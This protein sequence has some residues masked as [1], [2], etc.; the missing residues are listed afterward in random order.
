MTTSWPR[1]VAIPQ[2]ADAE[3][4]QLEL[5]RMKRRATGLLV[6]MSAVFLV[7]LVLEPGHPWLGYVRATAEAAMVGG[8]ADWFAI[9]ALFKHPL[10]IPIPHT[11]I[12]PT[13][14]DRIGRTL[15]N[16]VQHNFL[17]PEILGPKLLATQP[18]RR[19]A[20]WLRRPEN[21]RSLARHAAS[22][23]RSATDVVKDEDVHALLERSVIE[24]LRQRP[25]A[26][27]LAKGLLLLTAND[28]HQ[29]LLDRMIT[30]LAGLIIEN[31][32]F[33][34]GRIHAESPWWV[35][36][37][38]DEQVHAKVVAGIQRTLLEVSADPSHPMRQQFDDLL[39]DWIVRLQE[40]PEAI[41]RADA[42]KQQLFD[43]PTSRGLSASLWEE[44]KRMLDRQVEPAGSEAPGAMER[45]LIALAD[46]AL[47]D[48]VLLA[49]L[50][51]WIVEAV[52]RVV[53]QHRHEVGRLIEHT[54]SNW[55]PRET[56][57]R[58][59]LAVGRDLQFVRINGT[60]VGGL[61][62]LILYTASR[63]AGY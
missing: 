8:L 15:G 10:N 26:P 63:F 28:R 58:L 53:E 27:V 16:F 22:A 57:R 52:L 3:A 31:E 55:D 5:D 35:P 56:S 11:A 33:I 43:N 61:V 17:S 36:G 14:K 4:K 23:V 48:E 40:S 7:T 38:V 30:G 21:A 1:T 37:F 29:Q 25:I 46:G 59:E 45:G 44:V 18:S 42:L 24:P 54:V 39:T 47:G 49:K 51:G 50:D 19:V 62:G 9:T 6:A 2:V 34:R 32:E 12:I 41:A 13:R 60:L 20:E